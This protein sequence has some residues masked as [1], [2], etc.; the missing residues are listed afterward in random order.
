MKKVYVI[1]DP[2]HEKVICAH[3]SE[4]LKCDACI[5]ARNKLAN[6]PYCLIGYWLTIDSNEKL[7]YC[8][9]PVD[10]SNEDCVKYQLCKKHAVDC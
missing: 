3:S 9:N 7:C 5:T 2:L 4:G 10:T 8:G 1:Y 6:T